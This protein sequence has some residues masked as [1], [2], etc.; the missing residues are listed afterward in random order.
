MK[1]FI[2]V[3]YIFLYGTAAAQSKVTGT[4]T[5]TE[6]NNLL[7]GAVVRLTS[8]DDSAKW[9]G[10]VSDRVGKFEFSS[11]ANGLYHLRIN[12]IGYKT[13]ALEVAVNNSDQ[14]LGTVSLTRN[15]TPLKEINITEQAVRVV[16]KN[17]TSEYNAGS[18]KKNKDATTEDLVTKMP[19]ITSEGGTVK[20][21]GETVKKVLI[22]GKEYFGDDAVLALRNL[23]SEIVDRVQVFDRMSDQSSFT[24]FDDGNSQRAMN[25]LT[26][27]GMNNGVFGKL[28]AGYG[29]LTDSRY[30]AGGTINWFDG[31]RRLS[32]IGMSN[33]VNQQNFSFQD[34]LGITGSSQRGPGMPGGGF[35]G[36]GGGRGN[37]M[38]N[39]AESNFIVGQQSGI[40]TTHSAGVN[41]SDVWGKKKKLKITANY[42]FNLTDNANKSEL[43]RTYF[44]TS[45][46]ST[47][48]RELNNTSS[49]N[50]NHRA[51]LRLEYV[52]DSMNSIFFTPRF[53]YQSNEQDNL[54]AG[55][56]TFSEG[57]LLSK[58]Q[59]SYSSRNT[60]YNATGE[61]LYQ[62]KF[63]KLYR[64]ISFNVGTTINNKW[65]KTSQEALNSYLNLNDSA[66]IDQ[67]ANTASTSHKVN[68]NISYTE[69]AGKNAMF[70]FSYE[71]SYTWNK[72]DK[73][74]FNYDTATLEHSSLDTTLSSKYDNDYM[75]HRGSASYRLKGKQFNLTLGIS[76]QY[77][78]LT[79]E[80]LFPAAFSIE[81]NFYNVLPNARLDYRFKNSSNLRVMYRTSTNPPSISQLQSVI[82]NSNPLLLST[83]NP[84]LKQSYSHFMMV[85]YGFTNT[86]KGQSFFAF[87]SANYTQ[88]YIGNSAIIA[89]Q[90]TALTA[91]VILRSGS[92]LT[93]PVNTSGSVNANSFFT[94]GFPIN[95]IKCNFNLNAGFTFIR[96]PSLINSA[97][98]WSNTYG[99]N[100]GFVFN[101]NIS[102]KIDFTL[103]YNGNY[104][105]VKNTLQ[106]SSDNNY[107][108]HN[109]NIKFNWQFWKGFVFNTGLLNTLF[110]GVAD[111]Y[112]Q[113]IFLWSAALGYKFLKDQS[114][115]VRVSVNDILNQN[116]GVSR[117]VAETYVEDSRTQVLKRYLLLTVTYNLRLA[118]KK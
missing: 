21:Q 113:N 74:T 79:G 81:R 55:Q 32:F 97:Q 17:D 60:G 70:Q 12:Y 10:T 85:R 1:F 16:Q 117:I 78:L 59:S 15:A 20:A 114:L 108:T 40:A 83:G 62:H 61:F 46:T 41:F 33:N 3:I 105:V 4:I 56:N 98:N 35:S 5:D 82:D 39:S 94:Y 73:K 23:P 91:E 54:I 65:G 48:Y 77:A 67:Q 71:P 63:K 57:T 115:D 7:A 44:N 25:I 36:R 93:M 95:K 103:S 45:D 27:S 24:G 111:G 106:S 2:A 30:S 28:Y 14:H 116:S 96:N 75:T 13:S 80:A 99:V 100:G 109:A 89:T 50:M 72:A 53:N 104:N 101:S 52:I 6:D 11:I 69:L 34:L 87:A 26:K 90:D 68:G 31:N 51:G 37:W 92:Q 19:G 112:E 88:N 8:V 107:F 42:F 18:F 49:R 58:T 66:T 102:E 43:T 22:D 76:G 29:Y 38:G 86:K 84:N 110:T 9:Q 118:I 64:T 47:V